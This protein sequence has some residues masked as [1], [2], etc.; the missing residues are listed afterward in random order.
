MPIFVQEQQVG[1]SSF[2]GESAAGVFTPDI[3]LLVWRS[4]PSRAC[5]T[6]HCVLTRSTTNLIASITS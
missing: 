6:V 4:S 3:D 5:R 1:L 2:H